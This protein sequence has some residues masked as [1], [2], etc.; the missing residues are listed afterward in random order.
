MKE[1]GQ[2]I[3]QKDMVFTP[4][5]TGHNI[6]D[7][8]KTINSMV[9]EKRH[10][11]MVHHTKVIMFL[12]RNMEEVHLYG[13]MDQSIMDNFKTIILKEWVN[14]N[15]LMVDHITESGRIIKCMGKV[16]FSGQMGE[17]TKES[18]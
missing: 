14:I 15:G 16:Y 3:K 18:I 10:G 4:I 2:M 9:L 1:I 11:L 7:H 13:Q 12:E 6:K 17:D 5:K 8:G